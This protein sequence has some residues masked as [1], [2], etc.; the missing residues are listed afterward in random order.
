MLPAV[1]VLCG[2]FAQAQ[3]YTNIVVFGD[4]LSDTGNDAVLSYEKYGVAIPGPAA[5]YTLGRFTD[6]PD[7]LPPA[8]RYF[9]VWVEQMAAAL[10]THPGV[11]ASLEGGTNY[12]YGYAKTAGGT[13]LLTFG[14]GDE[15][16]IDVLNVGAQIGEYLALHPK[17]DSHTLFV[18]W[19][20]AN[21]VIEAS[22]AGD[23]LDAAADQ[24][25]NIQRLIHAGATQF[26]VLN[27]PPLGLVPRFNISPSDA[28]TANEATVLYNTAL[29][30]G[31]SLLP[32]LNFGKHL[33]IYKVDVFSL[34]KNIVA[35]PASYGFLNVTDSSQGIPVDP[36][37]YL[38]WDDLHPTTHGHNVLAMTALKTIEPRGCTVMTSPGEYVGIAAAGCR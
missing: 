9:G 1:L 7:T 21:D 16:S 28:K 27:L 10:P 36:D 25:G 3:Q 20:G 2:A 30:G 35:A 5:D 23:V 38:F 13:T 19:G 15:L 32:L 18:V 6:G 14:P 17:I 8:M 4:S 34:V 22:S 26:L 29:D 37:T 11:V 33:T 24:V 31:V 12:A